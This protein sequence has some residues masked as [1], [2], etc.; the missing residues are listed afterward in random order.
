M[1]EVHDTHHPISPG[2]YYADQKDVARDRAR[3]FRR[4]RLPKYL[5]YF[6]RVLRANGGRLVGRRL[7]YADLSLFQ[8]QAGLEYAFPTAMRRFHRRCPAIMRL[9][10]EVMH[11]PRLASYLA[12]P[13]RLA[14]NEEG[15]FR[16]YPEL[17]G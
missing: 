10:T 2:L 13:R 4:E 3:H 9:A 7:T 14:F 8:V 11:A 12:S 5:G 16:R 1:A 17:D 15:I 6:E